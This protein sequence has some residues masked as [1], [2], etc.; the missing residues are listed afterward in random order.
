[1]NFGDNL[2]KILDEKGIS[3][4]QFGFKVGKEASYISRIISGNANVTWDTIIA[5]AEALEITPG[6][7]F[8]S[9]DEMI[10]FMLQELPEDMK[11]FIRD[12]KNGP[13]LYLAKDLSVENLTPD[14]IIKVVQLWKETV[15]K[16]K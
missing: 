1:M 12:R 8:A 13:W 16:S 5:F 7:F 14:Q 4:R 6:S 11:E 9:E 3:Q 15:E 10:S 2:K